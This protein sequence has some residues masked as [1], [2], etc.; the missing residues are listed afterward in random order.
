MKLKS[1]DTKRAAQISS[2]S[3]GEI[4]FKVADGAIKGVTFPS[5]VGSLTVEIDSYSVR[6][7]EAEVKKTFVLGFFAQVADQK[8]FVE[9]KFD[10]ESEREEYINRYL[11]DSPRDEM[12]MSEHEEVAQ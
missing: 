2:M 1:I 7:Y 4:A 6:V 3:G 12:A 10:D 5:P 8:L 11:P 9:K